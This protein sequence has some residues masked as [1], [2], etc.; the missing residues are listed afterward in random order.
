MR[1]DEEQFTTA[2]GESKRNKRTIFGALHLLTIPQLC[3]P[4]PEHQDEPDPDQGAEDRTE[5]QSEEQ[6]HRNSIQPV[7][8][9]SNAMRLRSD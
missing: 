5:Q 9:V 4:N 7:G 6:L 2:Q 8:S 1:F 3:E